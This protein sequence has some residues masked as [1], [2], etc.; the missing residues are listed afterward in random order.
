MTRLSDSLIWFLVP[1][2]SIENS[3]PTLYPSLDPSSTPYRYHRPN[4][5]ALLYH[6]TQIQIR[7]Q[8]GCHQE[9]AQ[10]GQWQRQAREGRWSYDWIHRQSL[11]WGGSSEWLQGETVSATY[12]SGCSYIFNQLTQTPLFTRFDSSSGRGAFRTRIGVGAVIQGRSDC[13]II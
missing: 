3:A 8:D 12:S 6:Q 13:A 9:S 11:R 1:N 4:F 2:P 7:S 5:L 10:G